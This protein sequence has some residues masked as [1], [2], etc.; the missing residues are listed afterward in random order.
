MTA[1]GETKAIDAAQQAR[2]PCSVCGGAHND[3]SYDKGQNQTEFLPR[4]IAP[5][6]T[7]IVR[8]HAGSIMAAAL[9]AAPSV[10][11][12]HPGPA[13]G[14][15]SGLLHPFGGLDHLL[16]LLAMGMWAGACGRQAGI[17]VILSLA[18][19][20]VGALLAIEGIHLP[21]VEYG[22]LS[23]VLI[24]GLVVASR[25]RLPQLGIPLVAGFAM[26]H[27]HAH[28]TELPSGASGMTFV[29]GFLISSAAIQAFGLG[30]GVALRENPWLVRTSGAFIALGGVTLALVK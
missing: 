11:L 20:S 12:A 10:A 7:M 21:L 22:V 29:A 3:G 24:L 6:V 30:L 17:K 27:G 13:D 16:A 1:P 15:T 14:L 4:D 5:E 18:A 8:N 2:R 25:A 23:S 9:L 19:M 26:L 28:G